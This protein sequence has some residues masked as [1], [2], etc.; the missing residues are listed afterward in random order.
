LENRTHLVVTSIAFFDAALPS[1][2]PVSG[3]RCES[4]DLSPSELRVLLKGQR[5]LLLERDERG[6]D[7]DADS[8]VNLIRLHRTILE[9]E[10]RA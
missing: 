10:A 9:L 8:V 2:Q 7:V 6:L 3:G 4:L 1:E 5:R